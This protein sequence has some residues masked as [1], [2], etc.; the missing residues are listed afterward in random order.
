MVKI[1]LEIARFQLIFENEDDFREFIKRLQPAAERFGLK[2]YIKRTRKKKRG[3]KNEDK[4][5]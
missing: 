4:A 2:I 1:N 5:R 3:G